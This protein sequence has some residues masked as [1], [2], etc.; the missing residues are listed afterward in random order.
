MK[1]SR[2]NRDCFTL[3]FKVKFGSREALR[4]K[5]LKGREKLQ[6][7]RVFLEIF[8]LLKPEIMWKMCIFLCSY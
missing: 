4:D 5:F 8:G 7:Q 3:V 1:H 2:R 6:F